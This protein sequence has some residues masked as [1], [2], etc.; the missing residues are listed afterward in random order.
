MDEQPISLDDIHPNDFVELD[1]AIRE[2]K[3]SCG[4]SPSWED[5]PVY[6]IL[7]VV[8]ADVAH[9]QS[10]LPIVPPPEDYYSYWMNS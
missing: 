3:A 7:R 2:S 8:S 10:Q 1:G 6:K 5:R 4:K 9:Q